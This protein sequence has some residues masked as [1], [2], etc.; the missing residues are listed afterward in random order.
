MCCQR[1][2]KNDPALFGI[3]GMSSDWWAIRQAAIWLGA[4]LTP[5]DFIRRSGSGHGQGWQGVCDGE[6]GVG[7]GYVR[8][9]III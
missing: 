4:M 9:F 8:S 2:L 6:Q 5:L 3:P 1:A 7:G